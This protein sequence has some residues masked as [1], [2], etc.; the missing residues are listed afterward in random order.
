MLATNNVI[1]TPLPWLRL[2][3][4]ALN[5][6][7]V[8]PYISVTRG[9]LSEAWRIAGM[10]VFPNIH[11]TGPSLI[12][13]TLY[14][15]SFLPVSFGWAA[16]DV[17]LAAYIQATLTRIESNDSHVSSLGAVMAFL[18]VL[19]IVVY[20]V[21]SSV[22]GKWVDNKL[23]GLKGAATAVAA[24]DALKYIGGV[25]FTVLC[26]IVIISTFIPKGAFSLN[27]R[28]DDFNGDRKDAE[29]GKLFDSALSLHGVAD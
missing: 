29:K 11:F 24:R 27:P 21:L 10:Y 23:K 3:A 8:L 16:G 22:L 19:Y 9:N 25:Q 13:D 28:D 14:D 1:R 17:S 4:L 6:V 20:A 12:P 26:V 5:I 18:Y 15:L 2:D 7:W